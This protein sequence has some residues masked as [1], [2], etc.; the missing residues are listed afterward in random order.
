MRDTRSLYIAFGDD[1]NAR[2]V[3]ASKLALRSLDGIILR[4]G[5]P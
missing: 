2:S 1:A 5:A 3:T 4:Q